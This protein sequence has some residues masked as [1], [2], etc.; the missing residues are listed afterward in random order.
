M[1][2]KIQDLRKEEPDEMNSK[3]PFE[4]KPGKDR[5]RSPQEKWTKEQQIDSIR[6]PM[7]EHEPEDKRDE[8]E[9][10]QRPTLA[11]AKQNSGKRVSA[12]VGSAGSP[13]VDEPGRPVT[14]FNQQGS[15]AHVL[16]VED[17]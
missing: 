10:A 3:E 15:R 9:K 1:R 12:N 14:S 4:W 6:S 13:G 11:Q 7:D 5:P 17:K 8:Y 2:D 16:L